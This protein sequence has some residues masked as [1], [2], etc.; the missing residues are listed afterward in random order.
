MEMSGEYSL[1][2]DRVRVWEALNDPEVL[3][4][5]LPGCESME[6]Q[7]EQSFAAVISSKIGPVKAKFTAE[8]ALENVDA[9]NGYSIVGQGKG[10]VAGFASG[11]AHVNLS[12][13]PDGETLL[14]YSVEMQVGGKLAQIGSRL[15]S[16]AA[17]K[18]SDQFFA[19]FAQVFA[20]GDAT[21]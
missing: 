11:A 3:R 19:N 7:D 1:A 20:P 12:D 13:A 17:R 16:G 15:V 21:G 5:C 2:A 9:P 14:K 6:R 10:G 18:I 4:S 8:L